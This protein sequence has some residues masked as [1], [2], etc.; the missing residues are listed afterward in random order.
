MKTLYVN[1]FFA[2]TLVVGCSQKR[3]QSNTEVVQEHNA[4]NEQNALFKELDTLI[5]SLLEK[6]EVP[7]ITVSYIEDAA[8]VWSGVFGQRSPDALAD[9]KTLYLCASITKPLTT[10]VFLRLVDQG[11]V[12][13]DEPMYPYYVDADIKDD[14]RAKLLTPRHV[15]T[16]QTGFKNWRRMTDGVLKFV[17][18][19]G[20]QMG[21]SGEG[22]QYLVRFVE[23][24]LGKPFNAIAQE[25]LFDPLGMENSA[26]SEQDWYTDRL[27]WPKFPDGNWVAPRTRKE[28][29]GAGGLFTTSA[30]YAKFLI[31]ILKNEGVSQELR[32]Q[33][34]KI[35]LNQK[36]R[37]LTSSGDPGA[38]PDLLGFGLGWYIYDFP[39]E[40][41]IGH[42][43]ANLGERT[44]AMFSPEKKSGF[45]A[46]TNGANGNYVIFEVA[47]K[48]GL[49]KQFLA[50]ER[51]KKPFTKTSP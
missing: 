46:M 43:G 32:N 35:S 11:K 8:I 38:C 37:C 17:N 31:S 48:L 33:Q 10:E 41:I 3:N 25:V 23:Q 4:A 1:I 24:K 50:I 39:E 45:V 29:F 15:F 2:L 28:A 51:P 36:E 7:S 20:T 5:P 27:A 26:L 18:N 19:P 14:P 16:H 6:Y 44:L 34:F 49:N 12:S 42:T 22:F 13:L 40:R 47:E 21:Y 9:S 30:D